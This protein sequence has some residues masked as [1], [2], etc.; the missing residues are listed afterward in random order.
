ML[1]AKTYPSKIAVMW[2]QAL[3]TTHAAHLLS[4]PN[5]GES[6]SPILSLIDAK[7]MLLTQISRLRGRVSLITGQISQSKE[8]HDN[9]IMEETLLFYQDADSSDEGAAMDEVDLESESDENWEEMS[10]QE[11]QEEQEENNEDDNKSVISNDEN[12]SICS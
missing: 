4:H 9:N 6:L 5:I 2:L 1:Q 11:E 10:D 8:E 7:L 12:D 3:V